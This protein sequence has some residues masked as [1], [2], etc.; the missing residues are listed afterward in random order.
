MRIY[1]GH[2][3]SIENREALLA[4]VYGLLKSVS[5]LQTSLSEQIAPVRNQ[6]RQQIF[7]MFRRVY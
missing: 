2:E 7:Q 3:K 4:E 5:C 1:N 6:R